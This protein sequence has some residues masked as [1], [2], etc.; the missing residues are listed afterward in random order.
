MLA[1][2]TLP[3]SL[4]T[5]PRTH[6]EGRSAWQWVP[7]SSCLQLSSTGVINKPHHIQ[8][9][10][11]GAFRLNPDPQACE[12]NPLL[13]VVSARLFG[14]PPA[15]TLAVAPTAVIHSCSL[16]LPVIQPSSA[17]YAT[18]YASVI[19]YTIASGLNFLIGK[20]ECHF[21]FFS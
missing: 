3:I 8:H 19:C 21:L 17:S 15:L 20:L 13:R 12:A 18:V 4:E 11:K 2:K 5:G 1:S 16:C 10:H 7:T 6:Q 9:F 14:T